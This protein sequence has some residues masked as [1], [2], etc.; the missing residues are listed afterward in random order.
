MQR[1]HALMFVSI[2][3]TSFLTGGQKA[4]AQCRLNPEPGTLGEDPLVRHVL[5][6]DA[7][8]ALADARTSG[9]NA[10]EAANILHWN[11]T[12]WDVVQ[13]LFPDDESDDTG[14]GLV[15]TL[16]G[17]V[18]VVG[19][20]HTDCAA[21]PYCGAVYVYRFDGSSWVLEAT[22][23]NPNGGVRDFFGGS[24]AFNGDD[25]VVRSRYVGAR[26]YRYVNGTWVLSGPPITVAQA[27]SIVIDG[28]T[29][30]IGITGAS[31]D[32]GGNC[33]EV[34]VYSFNGSSWIG[35]SVLVA[36]DANYADRFGSALSLDGSRIVVGV[37][38]RGAAYVFHRSDGA[39]IQEAKLTALG[40]DFGASVALQDDRI[41]VGAPGEGNSFVR[42]RGAVYSYRL[43]DG[44]WSLETKFVGIGLGVFGGA[45]IGS[46]VQIAGQIA[47][48]GGE[49]G[50]T[51]AITGTDCNGNGLLDTCEGSVLPSA[52]EQD[53]PCDC[54]SLL[55]ASRASSAF[56]TGRFLSIQ[57]GNPGRLSAIRVTSSQL[58]PPHD[59]VN[60]RTMWV[61]EA[62]EVSEQSSSVAPSDAPEAPTF[63][64]ARL[65]CKP[66]YADRSVDEV[67]HVY[68]AGIVP[69]GTYSVQ[70]IDG[71]CALIEESSY[72]LP[73]EIQT[74]RWGDTVEDCSA[75]PC[76]AP[77]GAID[78]IDALAIINKFSNAPGAIAKV[79]ADL[80][81]QTPDLVINI[82]DAIHA[83]RAFSGQ[84]YPFTVGDPCK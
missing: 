12:S 5:S 65:V 62:F 8:M 42:E 15:G 36:A 48:A 58:P 6:I 2:L 75:N 37:K 19:A 22:L 79:R 4:Q 71:G 56:A 30:A 57:P 41:I 21:G 20:S 54:A 7:G 14:F 44:N 28:D 29:L 55:T 49:T 34:R 77:N 13:Q 25:L 63:M 23:T 61:G 80:E 24:V 74:A 38:N 26:I 73:S 45:R 60:G 59:T 67:I 27:G 18:A 83:L 51:F 35:E 33:G 69:G 17:D 40:G 47:V 81:P 46:S 66:F 31:C 50:L 9:T 78:I 32:A 11:G 39:W 43:S 16:L 3:V 68:G 76:A 53:P 10:I 84:A 70:I 1:R 64:A 72:S 82:S 52:T